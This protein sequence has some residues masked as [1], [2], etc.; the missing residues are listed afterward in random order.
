M[1]EIYQTVNSHSPS[2]LTSFTRSQFAGILCTV[3]D[4]GLLFA[5]VEFFHIWY[6]IAVAVGAIAGAIS[7]FWLNRYWSFRAIHQKWH[8]QAFRYSVASGISA[9]L[10]TAGVYLL[11]DW[12]KIHYSISVFLVSIAVGV[13]IN[14][15]LHRY[16]VFR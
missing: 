16:F 9:A 11:T 8:G 2:F 7:N 3:L 15:P 13:L 14:Y 6:V 4:W 5:L 1:K 12:L 10:N